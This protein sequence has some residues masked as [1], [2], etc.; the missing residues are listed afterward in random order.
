MKLKNKLEVEETLEV[1]VLPNAPTNNFSVIFETVGMFQR[2]QVGNI[3][4]KND[5]DFLPSVSNSFPTSVF[6]F[7]V[8]TTNANPNLTVSFVNQVAGSVFAAPQSLNGT[9]AF[10]MLQDS[11]LSQTTVAFQNDIPTS[12]DYITTNTNQ[13]GLSGNKTT[14]GTWTFESTSA[15]PLRIE[16]ANTSN[17]SLRYG[18]NGNFWYAGLANQNVYAIGNVSSSLSSTANRLFWID[19]TGKVF[20]RSGFSKVGATDDDVLLAGGGHRPVS[21]FAL[22]GS[23]GNYLPLA[24]GT[25]TGAIDFN[26]QPALNYLGQNRIHFGTNSTVIRGNSVAGSPNGIFFRPINGSAVNQVTIDGDGQIN[27]ANHGNSSQW[28]QAYDWGD[29]RDYGLGDNVASTVGNWDLTTNYSGFVS[30]SGHGIPG[31]ST[32]RAWGFKTAY[33]NGTYGT[34][35]SMRG[36]RIAF[37]TLENTVDSGWIEIIHDNNLDSKTSALGFIKSSALSGY[38]PT[39]RTITINGVTQNLSANRTWTIPDN[40][41][42]TRLRGTATGTFTSGDLTLLAGA[43]IGVTQSGANITITNSSPNIVQTLGISG[44]TLSLSGGGGSV[45]LPTYTLPTASATVL[46]GIKVGS[47]LSIDANGVLS[48]TNTNTTYT[49]GTGLSL[50][51]TT[52]GQAITTNGTGTFVTG[53]TQTANGFQVNLGTPPN[54]NT[55]YTGSN[56]INVTGTV[57]SPTYGTTANT[58]AQGNDSRIN[59]GQT[60]FGWGNHALAGYLTSTALNNYYQSGDVNIPALGGDYVVF[61]ETGSG[62]LTNFDFDS[63]TTT[64]FYNRLFNAGAA[65]TYNAPKTGYYGFVEVSS[66]GGNLLQITRPYRVSDG[67][68]MRSRFGG[69]WTPWV[70]F[71]HTG[72]LDTNVSDL[73]YTTLPL[74]QTWVNSQNF[75]TQT[76]TAGANIQITGNVISATDTNTTYTAGTGLSLTGTTFGQAITTSGTGTFVTGVTQTADGFQVNLGTPPNTT[77]NDGSFT[78]QGTGSITGFGSTSANAS[79]NTTATLDLTTNTKNDIQQGVDAYAAL[80]ALID[81]VDYHHLNTGG[82]V[83]I[84]KKKTIVNIPAGSLGY[85][86]NV[87]DALYDGYELAINGCG[88]WSV[89]VNGSIMDKCGDTDSITLGWDQGGSALFWWSKDMEM[90]IQAV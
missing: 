13:T 67:M 34:A 50:S 41:T 27:T 43:G 24:G 7:N 8:S 15:V 69:N 72:N 62:Q 80:P 60:A 49:A 17:I 63:I 78:V 76:L 74:V 21:D 77:P 56:G 66:H 84:E 5:T 42:V 53:I 58:I 19:N 90:W 44:N 29:F 86:I 32:G 20:G 81:G 51:G 85:T 38:V 64:G 79:A 39:S 30:A 68:W 22:A 37:K 82:H 59:N 52:F 33:G 26:L 54:T 36:G 48:A 11:D 28:K 3:I 47:N 12:S 40:D 70:E 65:S 18:L 45:T 57:I 25:M 88:E 61:P 73:G 35:V 1:G 55:T 23:L 71:I 46:G 9:P 6:A 89:T 2:R 83:P 4:N 14:S 16:N 87:D 10:R 31:W 75:S